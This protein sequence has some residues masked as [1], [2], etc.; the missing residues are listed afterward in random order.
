[1]RREIVPVAEALAE[2]GTHFPSVVA[3]LG[4]D[5]HA[6]IVDWLTRLETELDEQQAADR[7]AK[8]S[9]SEEIA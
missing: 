8:G 5:T 1:M 2:D 3:H 4:A 7:S 9:E 6:F